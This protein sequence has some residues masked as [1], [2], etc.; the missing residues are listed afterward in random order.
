MHGGHCLRACLRCTWRNVYR[1]AIKKNSNFAH[2]K[3]SPAPP[4]SG[5]R[6][7]ASPAPCTG[8]RP[9]SRCRLDR[10][11]PP[12]NTSP[13]RTNAR[14]RHSGAPP[15]SRRRLPC[16][17]RWETKATAGCNCMYWT[18]RVWYLRKNIVKYLLVLL[19]KNFAHLNNSLVVSNILSR[20]EL[21]LM[22][23]LKKLNVWCTTKM[24]QADWL[25]ALKNS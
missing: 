4:G 20:N 13:R 24:L 17:A 16:T 22:N 15:L 10:R 9:R 7:E 11:R 1:S 12:K 21:K 25:P 5:L 19:I 18:T 8:P 6:S 14:P 2:P 23:S 3:W